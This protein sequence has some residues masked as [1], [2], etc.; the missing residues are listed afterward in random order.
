[1][2]IFRH[3]PPVV[4]CSIHLL[5][6][7]AW[8]PL[9]IPLWSFYVKGF[10]CYLYI[11]IYIQIYPEDGIAVYAYWSYIFGEMIRLDQW[12]PHYSH[13]C[14]EVTLHSSFG[15]DRIRWFAAT[16][17]PISARRGIGWVGV[18]CSKVHQTSH[19]FGLL[20]RG[21]QAWALEMKRFVRAFELE[22]CTGRF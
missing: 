9:Y 4:V 22:F 1:M 14:Y 20:R 10:F 18:S 11:Y 15:A 7:L 16:M 3:R 21:W 6:D 17:V 19:P 8:C 12:D 5:R 2:L 13:I